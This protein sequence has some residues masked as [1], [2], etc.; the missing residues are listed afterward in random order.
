MEEL[1][2]FKRELEILNSEKESEEKETLQKA[3]ALRTQLQEMERKHTVDIEELN[4]NQ[5]IEYQR[6][7]DD[8]LN[9]SRRLSTIETDVTDAKRR[10]DVELKQLDQIKQDNEAL[11][12]SIDT[13]TA[14]L[15]KLDHESRHL[16]SDMEVKVRV[17][18]IGKR[19]EADHGRF[20]ETAR[21]ASI[22]RKRD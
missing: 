20:L 18:A 11:K 9:F 6:L 7:E 15:E 22:K 16:E 5:R 13:T 3:A 17:Q 4:A 21:I 1:N 10:L 19:G 12:A 8:N 14:A 2:G